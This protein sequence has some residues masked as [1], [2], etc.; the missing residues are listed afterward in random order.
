MGARTLVAL[1]LASWMVALMCLGVARAQADRS[2]VRPEVLKLPGKPGSVAGIGDAFE[3]PGNSG[4]ASYGIDIVMPPGIGELEPQVRLTY[5]DGGGHGPVGMGWALS[6]PRVQRATHRGLP[7]Y[8]DADELLLYGDAQGTRNPLVRLADGTLRPRIEGAFVR[9]TA[10]A[11]GF[12]FETPDGGSLRFGGEGCTLARDGKAFAWQLCE[13]RNVRGHAVHYRYVDHDGQLYLERAVYNDLGAEA[14]NEVAFVWEPR[15]DVLTDYKPG[16]PLVTSQR[17]AAIEVSHGGTV[18]RR[19]ALGYELAD[20]LSRLVDVGVAG[21]DGTQLPPMRFSYAS[22]RTDSESLVRMVDGPSRGPSSHTELNDVNGDGLPDLLVMDPALDG[23]AYSWYENLDGMR[24]AARTTLAQ[25]P[26]VWLSSANVTLADMNGDGAADVLARLGTGADDLRYYPAAL[27]QGTDAPPV[28]FGESQTLTGNLPFALSSPDVRLVDLDLDGRTDVLRI[29]PSSGEVRAYLRTEAG[30]ETVARNTGKLVDNEVLTFSTGPDDAGLQLADMNGDGLEDLVTLRSGAIRYFPSYG[31]GNFGDAVEV[32]GAPLLETSELPWIRLSDLT[33]DGLADVVYLGASEVRI[34]RN[35]VGRSLEPGWTLSDVPS[36][37]VDTTVRLADMNGNG[38]T[39]IVWHTPSSDVPWRYLD[40]LP[41]GTPGLMTRIDNGLG[42]ETTLSHAGIGALRAQAR[43]AGE[44]WRYRA[45]QGRLS[46]AGI[47]VSTGH[48]P[49]LRTELGYFGAYFDPQ[50]RTFRGFETRVKRDIGTAI[51]VSEGAQPTL[52][53]RTRY[54]VGFIDEALSGQVVRESRQDEAGLRFDTV[55]NIYAIQRIDSAGVRF[56]YLAETERQVFEGQ[57]TPVVTR[58]T[59]SRDD[60]G[61]TVEEVHDGI[62]SGR[63]VTQ[64]DERRVVR[65]FAINTDAWM[66]RSLVR[67]ATYDGSTRLSESEHHYDGAP[68]EGLPLGEVTRGELT[69]VRT[70]VSGDSWADV[71]RLRRNADGLVIESIDARGSHSTLTYDETHRAFVREVRRQVSGDRFLTWQAEWDAAFGVLS[72][73]REPFGGETRYAYDGL[74]RLVA[75]VAPGDS[76]ALP[77]SSYTY[78]LSAPTSFIRA[79]SRVQSGETLVDVTYAYFDGSGRELGTWTGRPGERWQASGRTAFGARGLPELVLHES[80]LG[81]ADFV[82]PSAEAPGVRQRYDAL[83]RVVAEVEPDGATRS[84]RY[85][86]FAVESVDENGRAMARRHDGLGRLVRVT[87]PGDATAAYSYDA[88]DRLTG[89]VDFKGHARTYTYDG[90]GNRIALQD[91]NAGSWSFAYN[92]AGDELERRDP[93]GRVMTHT[94]DLLGRVLTEDGAGKTVRWHY[95]S[96][97]GD[98]EGLGGTEGALAWVEDAAGSMH[99]GYDARGRLSDEVRAWADG[100]QH[101]RWRDLDAQDRVTR[102]AW[103]DNSFVSRRY[104]G[105]GQLAAAGVLIEHAEYTAFGWPSAMRFGNGVTSTQTFDMRR[106]LAQRRAENT[107]GEALLD[108]ALT[109]DPTSRVIEEVD[110]RRDLSPGLSLSARYTYDDR[111]RLTGELREDGETHYSYDTFANLTAVDNTV[112]GGHPSMTLRYGVPD[113]HGALGPD[114]LAEVMLGDG[115]TEAFSYDGAGRLVADGTRELSWDG[116]GRLSQVVRRAEGDVIIERYTYDFA[117]RRIEKRTWR[118]AAAW[119]DQPEDAMPSPS[120]LVRYPFDDAE[121]RGNALVRYLRVDEHRQIRL[122]AI[123]DSASAEAAVPPALRSGARDGRGG[124]GAGLG[125]GAL[126]LACLLALLCIGRR[127]P[128]PRGLSTGSRVARRRPA[129]ALALLA[130]LLSCG[131]DSASSNIRD[132]ATELTAWPESAQLYL[133]DLHQSPVV[134]AGKTGS[135]E[136]L[137]AHTAYG[138]VRARSGPISDPHSFAG[139]EADTGSALSDFQARPYRAHLAAFPAVDPI[140][141]FAPG[142]LLAEPTR[143]S[144]YTYALGDPVG[145]SDPLGLQPPSARLGSAPPVT[146]SF[147]KAALDV[148]KDIASAV[149]EDT[150]VTTNALGPAGAGVGAIKGLARATALAGRS[151]PRLSAALSRS[152][153]AAKG[154]AASAGKWAASKWQSLSRSTS[155]ARGIPTP[156]GIA[157]QAN[158][159]AARA[160]LGEVQSGA[161]VYR[162]GSFGVQNTADAQFWSLQNPAATRGFANQMGM[163]GGAAKPDWIMGGTVSPGSPVITRPAPGI[164]ANAGGS[165]EAV[166]PSGGVRNLWFHMPD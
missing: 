122:D 77:T 115:N 85:V 60:F 158:T 156:H 134:R 89:V 126:A 4:A 33:G 51:G 40:V 118:G 94:Y 36:R 39:D 7:T 68:F 73:V 11:D 99:F 21:R 137:L 149:I 35:V 92:T 83:A 49:S 154:S 153:D 69:R 30:F 13:A 152:L 162:Q 130:P 41:D 43:A 129:L 93:T 163:P 9:G 37:A 97:R 124:P 79:E 14:R 98:V 157:N 2:G 148:G 103:P 161:T 22:L 136:V 112:P 52:V 67:E 61:N 142:N 143:L 106:R 23:G 75:E 46:L 5:S 141:L 128:T 54:D 147:G 135:A 113:E 133:H 38:T 47:E 71:Q 80:Y 78:S 150:V 96:P 1:G 32:T 95:D 139:N 27:S 3:A 25:S 42:A 101:R 82:M 125:W 151:A 119:V 88:L 50:T 48:G 63:D 18:L 127:T 16:F 159:P 72:L 145:Y 108:L 31:F 34:W 165:M 58:S 146:E 26:S 111:Y 17:L 90:L 57:A 102:Q 116:K 140:A 84:T 55:D 144:P 123:V 138:A 86:P 109:Y 45:A 114:R 104:N 62:V 110:G 74:G 155:A 81:S 76:A 29:E 164:G 12:V 91:P 64:G 8:T 87:E 121:V 107:A 120:S 117:D 132:T 28:G 70:W 166:V 15:T 19:Y 105:Q 160:A 59:F 20:G 131:G 10:T 65:T 56:A 44:P 100:T 6:M 66:L 53:T 24:F